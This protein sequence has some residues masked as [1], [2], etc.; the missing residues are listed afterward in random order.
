MK[1]QAIIE[2]TN[3][4]IGHQIE[5]KVRRRPE[6]L[7]RNSRNKAPSTGKLPPTPVPRAA[8]NPHT[9]IQLGA[10]PAAIPKT[11]ARNSVALNASLRPMISLPIPYSLVS[12]ESSKDREVIGWLTYPE[13]SANAQ[14]NK[15]RTSSVSHLCSGN[16][17]F[18]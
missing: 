3:C 6:A 4:P 14:T 2:E 11:P 8:N 5:S 12:F 16:I 13:T 1:P 10:A 18:L 9:P 7:G 17:E 15:Q